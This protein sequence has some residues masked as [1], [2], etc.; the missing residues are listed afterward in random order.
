MSSNFGFDLLRSG[1]HIANE[2]GKLLS[3]NKTLT[4]PQ[5]QLEHLLEDLEEAATE[6]QHF[7][8][9]RTVL[10]RTLRCDQPKF[11]QLGGM[12][13]IEQPFNVTG[14]RLYSFALKGDFTHLQRL[15]DQYLNQPAAEKTSFEYRPLT[16]LVFFSC[17]SM[18]SLQSTEDP[19]RQIGQFNEDNEAVFWVV[20][21]YGRPRESKFVVRNIAL[22]PV[23][24]FLNNSPALVSGRE[25]Y[26]WPKE[27]AWFKPTTYDNPIKADPEFFTLE[28]FGWQKFGTRAKGKRQPLLQVERQKSQGFRSDI[29][30]LPEVLKEFA[31]LLEE[32]LAEDLEF[33]PSWQLPLNLLDFL[34]QQ[35]VPAVYLK[36]FRDSTDGKYA[37]YQAIVRS[38]LAVA[39]RSIRAIPI[40]H[41]Y[42]MIIE[43]LDSH[44]LIDQ[45][46]FEGAEIDVLW[47]IWL[48][49]DFVVESSRE[50]SVLDLT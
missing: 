48:K 43:D 49:F 13:S 8:H 47:A 19:D 46:G 24:V 17:Q 23:Y 34:M 28:V 45:F 38:K 41:Q 7:L 25:I 50:S 10:Q 1:I 39:P 14:T 32:N 20:L 33:R 3:G 6:F 22:F 37:C 4:P 36:Q 16:N 9:P 31:T 26:G 35:E 2:I 15:C 40:L 44:P 11:V 29:E 5:P 42:K 30:E 21:A 18:E 27:W 12:Q